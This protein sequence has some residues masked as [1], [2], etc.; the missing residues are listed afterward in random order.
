MKT[1]VKRININGLKPARGNEWLLAIRRLPQLILAPIDK[2]VKQQTTIRF[3]GQR[4]QCYLKIPL[5]VSWNDTLA[6]T[7]MVE[8]IRSVWNRIIPTASPKSHTLRPRNTEETTIDPLVGINWRTK[9]HTVATSE[10]NVIQSNVTAIIPSS[11]T[12]K[13]YL[14][15][16]P[17]GYCYFCFLPNVAL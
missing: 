13:N 17:A 15:A 2:G 3:V 6:C 9:S 16:G 8:T 14:V 12:F 5:P 1:S 4:T 11:D 10:G 7:R